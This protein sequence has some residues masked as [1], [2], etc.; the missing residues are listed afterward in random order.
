MTNSKTLPLIPQSKGRPMT[1]ACA[2]GA[3]PSQNS[4]SSLNLVL[5]LLISKIIR[6]LIYS[7]VLNFLTNKSRQLREAIDLHTMGCSG[8]K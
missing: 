4:N 2:E 7:K 6:G 8:R 5:P 1:Q 3:T